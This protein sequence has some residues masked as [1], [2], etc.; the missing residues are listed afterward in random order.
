M[1]IYFA[2][3]SWM[4][5]LSLI[6]V[7]ISIHAT[8]VVMM[9]LGMVRIRSRLEDRHLGLRYV[10]PTLTGVIATIGLLLT[11]L[12][13]IEAAIWAAAYV[14]L[15]ALDSPIEAMLYSVDSM[16]TRGA[17]GLVL[18]AHWQMMGALEAA[19]GTL[20]FG[21]STAYIFGVMLVYWPM[22]HRTRISV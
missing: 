5:S 11:A 12:H 20:L 19:N 6:V 1:E 8:G 2:R 16:T 7:T 13:G 14:W 9:A 15:G 4:W 17:S 18:H 3:A 10:V 21:I 22:L